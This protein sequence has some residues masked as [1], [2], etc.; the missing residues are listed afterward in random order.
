MSES[1]EVLYGNG[2]IVLVV[3]D[4]PAVRELVVQ[5][6]SDLDYETREAEN[7]DEAMQQLA[8]DTSFDPLFTDVVLPGTMSGVGLAQAV[9]SRM[10]ELK[11]LL[12]SGY[13]SRVS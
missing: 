10:P 12:T 5:L 8:S 2:E 3:E 9:V 1:H 11:V 6:L 13:P 4:E 7:A